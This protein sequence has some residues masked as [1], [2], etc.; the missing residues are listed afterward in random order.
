MD[1]MDIYRLLPIAL[2]NLSCD[3]QGQKIRSKRYNRKFHMMLQEYEERS[4]WTSE[5]LREYRDLQLQEMVEYCYRYVPYYNS[6]FKESGINY[7]DIKTPDDLKMLPVLK[8]NTVKEHLKEF[9]S[10]NISTDN[11]KIH[12]TGGTTG[13]AL[14]FHTTWEEENEQW[15]CWWKYRKNL[16]IEFNQMCGLF[17]GKVIVPARQKNA[18]YWRLNRPCGQIY[19]SAYH[20]NERTWKN[21]VECIKK[22]GIRWLHG[23]PSAITALGRLMIKNDC[24]MDLDIVTT[25]SENL[26]PFQREIIRKAFLGGKDRMYQ[27]YGLTEG[28]ANISE[29]LEHEYSIDEDFC[30]VELQDWKDGYKKII[31]T[32]LKYHTMPLLRYDTG[33]LVKV[34][35]TGRIIEFNGRETDFI[36]LRDGTMIG[37]AGL[38]LLLDKFP[39]IKESQIVFCNDVLR[40][41]VVIDGNWSVEDALRKEI[42]KRVGAGI[43]LDNIVVEY[44]DEVQ[45]TSSGKIKFLIVEN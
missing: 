3:L 28:V 15:A 44:V 6:L 18:P 25:G 12:A 10:T 45:K 24:Y 35:A 41:R 43:S 39:E 5:Q 16:G 1:K 21:Y 37:A 23:Y 34:D 17:G 13:T 36:T 22:Y 30:I 42:H 14:L 32:P 7:K 4:L 8:K 40:V 38:T 20:I 31:G 19:F 2:Q 26:Y 27:H 33:D 11:I 9:V 29:N